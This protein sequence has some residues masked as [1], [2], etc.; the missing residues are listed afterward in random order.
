M[1]FH[2]SAIKPKITNDFIPYNTETIIATPKVLK[3]MRTKK[4]IPRQKYDKQ[5]LFH[6]MKQSDSLLSI[7]I[8]QKIVVLV[9]HSGLNSK[10]QYVTTN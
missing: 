3:L 6:V 2:F 8:P 7:P 5:S 4:E 1:C 9:S 10:D